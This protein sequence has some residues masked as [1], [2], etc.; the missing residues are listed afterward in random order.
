MNILAPVLA[1]GALG[2]V[3][4][5]L[6]GAAAKKFKVET[7]E[8]IELITELLP[9]ANCGGCGF[10]GCSALAKAI[11]NG[12]AKANSCSGCP[13]ENLKKISAI[14]GTETEEKEKLVARVL[15]LG[16]SAACKNKFNYEGISD[17]LSAVRYSGGAKA[18][19]YGCLG[20]GTC[21]SSC[22]FGA[23]S[24]KDGIADIDASLCVGCGVCTNVCPRN[25]IKLLPMEATTYVMCSS[26]DK[27]GVM[28]NICSVG[29]IGCKICEKNCPEGAITVADNLATVDYSKCTGCGICT[30]KCPK[31]IIL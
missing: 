14:M 19:S 18:C 24:I 1:L 30:E 6:L 29:C 9:G 5:A 22:K 13:L 15:C 31:G 8:R 11:A 3:F 26:K 27:G 12:T 2:L 25:V 7:D 10:A 20:Y 28:K 21:V 4:G 17:C 23:L 16:N